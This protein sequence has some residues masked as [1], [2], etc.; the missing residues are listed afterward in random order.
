MAKKFIHIKS[1]SLMVYTNDK[2]IRLEMYNGY[3]SDE[4][5][6]KFFVPISCKDKFGFVP[7]DIIDYRLKKDFN[8][9]VDHY[10]VCHR[11][12]W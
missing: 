5:V 7:K 12:G 4:L 3:F 1:G 10:S 2:M 9:V 11:P 8:I 6:A